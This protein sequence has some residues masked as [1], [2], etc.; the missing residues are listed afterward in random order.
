MLPTGYSWVFSEFG[1]AFG[2]AIANIYKK[3]YISEELYYKDFK[4]CKCG[5]RYSQN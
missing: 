1:P 4:Q 3:T 2:P 5:F